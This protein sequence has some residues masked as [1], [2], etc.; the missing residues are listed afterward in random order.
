MPATCPSSIVQ[1]SSHAV[2]LMTLLANGVQIYTNQL[3]VFKALS[4]CIFCRKLSWSIIFFYQ[5]LRT[6]RLCKVQVS[7]VSFLQT[8]GLYTKLL[9]LHSPSPE[10][11]WRITHI[12]ISV[13]TKSDTP[14]YNIINVTREY[15]YIKYCEYRGTPVTV[16]MGL[17]PM[18][19]DVVQ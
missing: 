19:C 15:T 7:V 12:K 18:I 6:L 14:R 13:C 9:Q 11:V 17:L 3:H 2:K 8:T 5:Y 4:S 1:V 16:W 10:P